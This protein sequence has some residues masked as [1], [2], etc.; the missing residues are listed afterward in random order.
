MIYGIVEDGS[1]ELVKIGVTGEAEVNLVALAQRVMA[2]QTG[3]PRPL[4]VAAV[5]PGLLGDEQKLHRRFR[6]HRARGEW[7]RNVGPVSE[8][9]RRWALEDP[10][11]GYEKRERTSIRRRTRVASPGIVDHRPACSWCSEIGHTGRDCPQRRNA[12]LKAEGGS[13]FALVAGGM[14]G[15]YRA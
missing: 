14:I 12:R 9:L 4:I 1:W 3:N 13:V 6:L 2:L 5:Q 11:C 8:W 15:K 7:F 10:L